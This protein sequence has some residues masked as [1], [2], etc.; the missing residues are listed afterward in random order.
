[1]FPFPFSFV[2]PTASGLAD[3]DNAYSMEFDGID[4][5][6][7]L[8]DSS[9]LELTN[10]FSIS[11]WINETSSLNR[12]VLV[13]GDYGFSQ[14]W[15][16]YRSSG[17]KIAFHCRARTATSTTSINTGAWFHVVATFESN[18]GTERRNR[19]YIN[20][21]LENTS[22]GLPASPTYT[23]TIYKQIAYPYNTTGN[24]FAGKLDEVA[25]FD[26]ALDSDQIDEI[27]NATSTGKTA[28]L[29]A[30]ATP[31]VAWYRMGD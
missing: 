13:C 8:G 27:Y 29:S 28:D 7:N 22:T 23:G 11:F 5:F 18:T 26:Y 30:M 24:E 14:G 2:A 3:I 20:G 9:A 10:N 15:R 21:S 16:V 12:G 31:P 17:N 1:M 4:D 25:V 6:V 19:I